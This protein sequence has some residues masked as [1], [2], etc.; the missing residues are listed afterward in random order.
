MQE[1]QLRAEYI[2]LSE[3]RELLGPRKK[4]NMLDR[5][6]ID[7][8]NDALIEINTEYKIITGRDIRLNLNSYLM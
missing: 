6:M 8:I 4:A 3:Q 1:I 5:L 7:D 2:D